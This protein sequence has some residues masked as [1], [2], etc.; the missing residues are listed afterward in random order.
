[1]LVNQL[2]TMQGA[3]WISPGRS[4]ADDELL[5]ELLTI[6]DLC[7]PITDPAFLVTEFEFIAPLACSAI[8][9]DYCLERFRPYAV[10]NWADLVDIAWG[11]VVLLITA[12]SLDGTISDYFIGK[13][14]DTWI[15]LIRKL[16]AEGLDIHKEVLDIHEEISHPS[17]N[18]RTALFY[19]IQKIQC[20]HTLQ[21]CLGKWAEILQAAGVDL[22]SYLD[23]ETPYC[24]E[25]FG[26]GEP[27][28]P[29]KA[30][31]REFRLEIV[32]GFAMPAWRRQVDPEGRLFEVLEE[33]HQFGPFQLR[34]SSYS[35]L[36]TVARQ[37]EQHEQYGNGP[38]NWKEA[39]QVG[40]EHDWPFFVPA[41]GDALGGLNDNPKWKSIIPSYHEARQLAKQRLDRRE[42]KRLVKSGQLRKRRGAVMPGSWVE[43]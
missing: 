20:P 28:N 23:W 8:K 13:K 10:E 6:L 18:S 5:P 26:N 3:C 24:R 21:I 22:Q 9:I 40:W 12:A 43:G 4:P 14:L 38:P 2:G 19:L 15:N 1:M 37:Y 25:H 29:D 11:Q 33:F 34:E 41:V 36:Q 27:Y 32:S 7:L 30:W 16:I 35:L 17:E 42:Q 39:S 31:P